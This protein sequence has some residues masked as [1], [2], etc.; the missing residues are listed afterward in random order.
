MVRDVS[1]WSTINLASA[2]EMPDDS[3]GV[4]CTSNLALDDCAALHIA[5]GSILLVL[6]CRSLL[7]GGQ[8]D[9]IIV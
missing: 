4:C 7:V 6:L 8:R 2:G 5:M 1:R 9:G 3:H